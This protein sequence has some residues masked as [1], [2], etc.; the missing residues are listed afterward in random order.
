MIVAELN[1]CAKVWESFLYHQ[2]H[3]PI[4]I[5]NGCFV[6]SHEAFDSVA[7]EHILQRLCTQNRLRQDVG[8]THTI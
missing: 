1:I 3:P 7:R 2:P 6:G 5:L 8:D 4:I